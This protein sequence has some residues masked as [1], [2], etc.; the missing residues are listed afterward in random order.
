M[1]RGFPGRSISEVMG[2]ALEESE[3]R[4]VRVV[5]EL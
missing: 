5:Y 2:S 3:G 1:A 4:P